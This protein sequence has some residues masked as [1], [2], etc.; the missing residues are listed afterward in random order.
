MTVGTIKESFNEPAWTNLHKFVKPNGRLEPNKD[1]QFTFIPSRLPPNVIYDREVIMLLAEAERKVGELK[2]MA[3]QLENPDILIRACLK[4]EAVLSS[5]IEGTLASLK[6]LNKLE[7]V[8]SIGKRD[9][10]NLRLMEVINHVAA[11]ETSL[12]ALKSPGRRIDLDILKDA[13][14]K[15]MDGVG[16]Y[17]K[18]PGQFRDQQNWI[19][20]TRGTKREIIYTPPPPEMLALLLENLEEFFQARHDDMPVLIQCAVAHYQF[21]AIHPFLDGN[22]RI[23]RLMLPLILYEKG[24]MPEPLL[25]LSAFFDEHREEYYGGL[26]DV[27]QNSSWQDWI[28]FFLWAFIE[29]ADRAINNVQRLAALMKK[30]KE[31]LREKRTG[32]NAILLTVHLF[33]NPYITVPGA[34]KFLNTTYPTAKNAIMAL[35]RA[36]ILKQSSMRHKSRVFIADE[37]E[38]TLNV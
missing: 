35:I 31:T 19:I 5:K 9:M 24:I 1:G 13:H 33:A 8:G 20:K 3:G 15:L 28:K 10:E 29:Q 7:A 6:D 11:L 34:M 27:S 18:N 32:G 22:G 25:C 23:G 26:L 30:Y 37:I 36:G 2:G 12:D 16:G 4:K 14:K 21:E 17:D 38:E